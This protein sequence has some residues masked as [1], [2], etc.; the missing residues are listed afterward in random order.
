MKRRT[1]II[2]FVLLMV[3]AATTVA[4]ATE[5][6][7]IQNFRTLAGVTVAY[8]QLGIRVTPIPPGQ[9]WRGEIKSFTGNPVYNVDRIGWNWW[10]MRQWCGS[11]IQVQYQFGGG[12][13]YQ[14]NST[15]LPKVRSLETCAPGTTRYVSIAAKHDFEEAGDLHQSIWETPKKQ[16]P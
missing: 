6:I 15:S 9:S 14:A 13:E 3:A 8:P 11:V 2:L 5:Y 1:L 4:L 10:T 16:A 7:F 12:A